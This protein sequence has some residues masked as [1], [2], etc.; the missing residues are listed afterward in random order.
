M[1]ALLWRASEP[2]ARSAVALRIQACDLIQV[3]GS[4]SYRVKDLWGSG[5]R[6]LSS[7]SY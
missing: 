6:V 5:F 7:T 3:S 2:M 1:Q 4:E